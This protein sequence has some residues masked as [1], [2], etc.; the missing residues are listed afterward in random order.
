MSSLS[1]QRIITEASGEYSEISPTSQVRVEIQL[2]NLYLLLAKKDRNVKEIGLEKL[3]NEYATS[4]MHEL[5][6]PGRSYSSTSLLIS[7]RETQR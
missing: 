2:K 5:T 6:V 4:K 1:L 7:D 3:F